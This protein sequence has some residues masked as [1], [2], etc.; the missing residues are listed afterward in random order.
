MYQMLR[1]FCAAP[2]ELEEERQEFLAALSAFNT[3]TAMPRGLLLVP[4]SLPPVQDKRPYFSAMKENIA[5]A[6]CYIQ[7]LDTAPNEGWGPPARNFERDFRQACEQCSL[8]A[9]LLKEPQSPPELD[10]RSRVSTFSTHAQLHERLNAVFEELLDIATV[11][12][13]TA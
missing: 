3:A 5:A 9:V 4:A 12:Q 6:R 2:W 1:V 7:L 11:R 8:V 13:A 10:P